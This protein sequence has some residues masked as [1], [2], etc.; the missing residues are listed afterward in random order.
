MRL[1]SLP[2]ILTLINLL[3]GCI[4]LV[5]VFQPGMLMYVPVFTA[6]SLVADFLDGMAA[7]LT[8]T[9][10]E[11]GKQLDS[12]A[13]MVS[14]GAVPGAVVYTLLTFYY[15]SVSQSASEWQ[16]IAYAAPAFLIT[17]FSALRLAKFN[18]D[19]RQHE[20]FIGLATPA[21]TLFVIGVL[22]VFLQN[23][24]G[25]APYI[26]QPLFLYT[27]TILCSIAMIAE[28][29]MFSFKFKQFS[30]RGNEIRYVYIIAVLVL[31][32]SLRFVALPLAI[33]LYVMLSLVANSI[34]TKNKTT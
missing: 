5:L 16:I 34:G 22:L 32:A 24:F 27:M 10:S 19:T 17:L 30:W 4:A 26:L 7:R 8:G 33:I 14:F 12:L 18:I 2:N 1:F 15:M 11:I 31:C 23:Q 9:G 6:I 13:D 28:I 20:S 25:L 3:S 21:N 29:P